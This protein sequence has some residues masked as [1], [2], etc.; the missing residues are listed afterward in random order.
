LKSA[1]VWIAGGSRS[2][3]RKNLPALLLE[4]WACMIVIKL[5]PDGYAGS[6]KDSFFIGFEDAAF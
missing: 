2:G 4:Y 1:F 6:G 5:K 3:S